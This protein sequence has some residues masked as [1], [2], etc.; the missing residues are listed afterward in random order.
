MRPLGKGTSLP[1]HNYFEISNFVY[2][3]RWIPRKFQPFHGI[4]AAENCSF[5]WDIGNI[6]G[7]TS[8]TTRS[9]GFYIEWTFN[10]VRSA[11]LGP[12]VRFS[13]IIKLSGDL[14]TR[15]V[16][17]IT[18]LTALNLIS[19][20]RLACLYRKCEMFS[21]GKTTNRAKCTRTT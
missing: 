20:L 3:K 10:D 12:L 16:G 21:Y 1:L 2:S 18:L 7:D 5:Q 4:Q 9:K 8:L 6:S 15:A 13:R 19:C 17:S 14:N 11:N